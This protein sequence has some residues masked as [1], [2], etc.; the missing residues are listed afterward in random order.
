MPNDPGWFQTGFLVSLL[1]EVEQYDEIFKVIGQKINAEDM[2]NRV[3]AIYAV[4][5]AKRGEE[6]EAVKLFERSLTNGFR[7]DR[8]SNFEKPL[9]TETLDILENLAEFERGD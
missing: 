2:D 3:L 8:F 9:L 1:Y 6:G 7:W 4:L 5:A